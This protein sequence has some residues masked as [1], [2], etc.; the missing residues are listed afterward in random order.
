MPTNWPTRPMSSSRC[1]KR[2]SW[3]LP[4]A[5]KIARRGG[6]PRPTAFNRRCSRIPTGAL[7]RD[8]RLI[9]RRN[10]TGA[11][12]DDT[13]GFPGFF[14]D[15]PLKTE[16][17]H[18]LMPDAS[19]ALPIA[20]GVVPARSELARRTLDDL[21]GPLEHPL[22]RRR[23]T[24]A[25]TPAASPISRGRGRLRPRSSC[26]RSTTPGT[27][28]AAAARSNGS[29]PARAAAPGCGS[30]RFLPRARRADLAAW[31]PGPPA[32]SRCLWCGITWG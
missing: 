14:P 23:A 16:R 10:V 13:A 20:L 29:T 5:R 24:T 31:S 22:V 2:P 6:G 1:A 27:S 18:R 11:V 21:E 17:A 4:W 8:G 32:R 28:T 12:A 9:K 3:R 7:V 25:T 15:V 30:R 19:M 26:G